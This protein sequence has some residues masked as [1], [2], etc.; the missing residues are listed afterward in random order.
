M[1]ESEEQQKIDEL[2]KRYRLALDEINAGDLQNA[3]ALLLQIQAE[4]PDFHET[5]RLLERIESEI[6][7]AE[8][9]SQL[10]DQTAQLYEQAERLANSQKWQQALDKME[11]IYLLDPD[12]EDSGGIAQ[13]AK[14]EIQKE[15][16]EVRKQ[17][18][19]AAM[20]SEAVQ[21]MRSGHYQQALEKLGEVH[22]Q[23]PKYPDKKKV[24]ATSRKELDALARSDPAGRRVP[25]WALIAIGGIVVVAIVGVVAIALAGGRSS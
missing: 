20:Y 2:E 24:K 4:Q 9:R 16:A 21:L 8:A 15:E 1:E 11:E 19:L 10:Q 23:D 7:R 3:H 6:A 25:R 17:N 13:E 18:E 14:D 12:F 5:P 22:E